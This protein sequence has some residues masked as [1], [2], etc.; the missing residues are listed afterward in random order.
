MEFLGGEITDFQDSAAIV[1]IVDLVI[2][3]DTSLVHLAGALGKS[4]WVL[5]A[6]VP[7]W[8]WLRERTDSAWYPTAR[9]FRQER[10]GDWA[11]V[12]ARVEAALKEV[13]AVGWAP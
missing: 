9:L 8:R 7:D 10:P 6:D 13:I 1:A 2:S 5:L 3:V 12:M 4:V 11:G